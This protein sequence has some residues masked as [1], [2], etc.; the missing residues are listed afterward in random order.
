VG[1]NKGVPIRVADVA[2]VT[3]GYAPRLGQFG[4]AYH[5]ARGKVRD[6][7]DAVEGVVLMRRGE[8]TQTVLEGVQKQT[9]ALNRLAG[10]RTS[11]S[12]K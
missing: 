9:A 5:D 6:N 11:V 8:Q 2:Q 3:T 1:A 12:R 4:F 7:P 10:P